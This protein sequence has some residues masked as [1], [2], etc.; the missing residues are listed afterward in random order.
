[1]NPRVTTRV[2]ALT[3]CALAICV[4]ATPASAKSLTA[5][6]IAN[7]VL[8]L[9]PRKPADINLFTSRYPDG[10]AQGLYPQGSAMHPASGSQLT[11]AQARSKLKAYLQDQFPGDNTKVNAALALFDGQKA[12]SLIA[13][14]TLRAAFVA[15]KGT[16][17]EPTMNYFLNSGR[18][19]PVDYLPSSGDY[20]AVTTGVDPRY[21]FFNGKYA[22]EDFR[23]L[24]GVFGHEVLHHDS[25]TPPAEEAINN[26]LTDMT[27]LQVLSKHPELAYKGTELSR[28]MND[29]ALAFLNSH[30]HG[31]PN[32]EIYAPT[33][34]GIAP[35][36]PRNAPDEWTLHGG[37]S[38]T[39][40]APA[41]LGHITRN[42]G[43]PSTSKFSLATAKTFE[44]LNDNWI[45]DVGRV[46][47]EVLL[48]MLSVKT[49]AA[50]TNL[51]RSKV[52]SKLHLRP[53]LDAVK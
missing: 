50:K 23:Y 29:G 47:I 32:S 22:S 42:L 1:M 35:G 12:K 25:S 48:Q 13:K 21:I 45:S 37:D 53:Y 28:Q 49:I 3:A 15:M 24:I 6:Q 18:F 36:S 26:P 27:Y 9:D 44:K 7:K 43:L 41:A 38:S 4:V 2:A 8:K 17:L 10:L 46:Q 14:P 51:S 20:V 39:S 11:E 19:A 40:P 33:G 16:L 52:I 34:K 30:E 5:K 31:S